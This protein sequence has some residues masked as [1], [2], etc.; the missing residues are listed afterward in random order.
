G[1]TIATLLRDH[2]QL[3]PHTEATCSTH[4]E[5]QLFSAQNGSAAAIFSAHGSHA[6]SSA[7]PV[8]HRSCAQLP[9]GS[10]SSGAPPPLKNVSGGSTTPLSPREEPLPSLCLI[11]ASR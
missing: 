7:E 5:S 8:T 10:S 2:G 6:G 3:W 9:A 4:S 11:W 1:G